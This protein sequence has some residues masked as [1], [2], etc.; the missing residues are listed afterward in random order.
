MYE[1]LPA[2][3][4]AATQ[5]G[6]PTAHDGRPA[7]RRRAVAIGG[8]GA[9]LAGA[10]LL[11]VELASDGSQVIAGSGS[12][13][14]LPATNQQD[15]NGT[16]GTGNGSSGDGSG[17]DGTGGGASTTGTTA[18][19]AQQV[20]VV[21]INTVLQYQGARAAGTGMVLTSSGEIL[22]NNH[23]IEGAT[24]ITV[25]VVST[26]ATYTASV[27][28]TDP[29]DDIAVLQLQHASGLQTA[30]F[31]DSSSV[32]VGDTVTGV[33]NAGG[34][35]GTPSAATGT[36]EALNQA[37]TASDDSGQ[38]AERL[39]GLIET[40]AAIVAGDSG[41]PLYDSS[42]HI[43]GMDTAA[44]SDGRVTNAAYAIPINH[45]LA[46]ADEIENGE[47]SSTIHLGNPGFLGVSVAD[48]TDVGVAITGVVAG[49]PA[50]QAG[51]QAGDVIT[52]IDGTAVTSASA[53]HEVLAADDPGQAVAVT[54]ADSS[55][56]IHH[57]SITL[58]TGPAD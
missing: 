31:G 18:T 54:W 23:V 11:T 45:A 38:N 12:V 10:A 33:G 7:R 52:A 57:S 48:V 34:T 40:D 14:V 47:E 19:A 5:A 58:A 9:L 2:T 26:G 8:V 44:S 39:T 30:S 1:Q 22:T 21:D 56:Q 35:G 51:M 24:S 4:D 25:T 16:G 55:G 27:V 42:G 32:Q 53:L 50:A 17:G 15:Q 37:I 41:G 13:A 6:G 3:P 49:S 20:G 36:V 43:V 28:G 46:I 29:T